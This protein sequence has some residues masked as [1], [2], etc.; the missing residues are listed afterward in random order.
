M[1]L[2]TELSLNAGECSRAVLTSR[3]SIPPSSK[4]SSGFFIL[5][6]ERKDTV[7]IALG[8]GQVVFSPR[9]GWSE[10]PGLRGGV[11]RLRSGGVST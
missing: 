9:K 10:M 5:P 2:T 7:A 11:G 3:S 1:R 6:R 4:C 8:E